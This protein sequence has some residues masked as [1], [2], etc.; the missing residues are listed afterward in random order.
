MYILYIWTY[1]LGELFDWLWSFP[2]RVSLLAT[3]L[4]A[5]SALSELVNPLQDKTSSWLIMKWTT[6]GLLLNLLLC[7]KM[8]YWYQHN[9]VDS[10]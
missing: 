1:L 8:F 5:S 6:Q 10:K 7:I 9:G 4:E 2:T 3:E